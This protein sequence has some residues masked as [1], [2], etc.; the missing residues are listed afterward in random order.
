MA[1]YYWD[2]LPALVCGAFRIAG[3]VW[4]DVRVADLGCVV[5]ELAREDELTL[6]RWGE[7]DSCLLQALPGEEGEA[8]RAGDVA[9]L[10]RAQLGL[11]GPAGAG[12]EGV[13]EEELVA[14]Q[15]ELARSEKARR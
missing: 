1:Q 9:R 13:A 14:L 12:V 10:G 6:T 11:E 7:E 2:G 8:F 4:W 5:V 15:A 3:A